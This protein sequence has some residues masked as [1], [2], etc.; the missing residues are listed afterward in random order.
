[1]NTAFIDKISNEPIGVAEFTANTWYRIGECID[2]LE[3]YKPIPITEEWAAKLGFVKQ[4]K[5]YY[6]PNQPELQNDTYFIEPNSE[7][8]IFI[9]D[10]ICFY[11]LSFDCCDG[12]CYSLNKE[13]LFVHQL[14]NIFFALPSAEL[15]LN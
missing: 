5:L 2:F 9:K 13:L 10:G 4:E 12:D 1:L 6:N 11:Q 7:Q 15:T 8:E 3:W 14:Q